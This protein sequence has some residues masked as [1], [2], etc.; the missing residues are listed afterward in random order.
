MQICDVIFEET[1]LDLR[2]LKLDVRIRSYYQE[3]FCQL[4]AHEAVLFVQSGCSVIIEIRERH[5]LMC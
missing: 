5:C 1:I 4:S 3:L 2:K